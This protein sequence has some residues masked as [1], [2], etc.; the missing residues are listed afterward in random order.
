MNRTLLFAMRTC[1][2]FNSLSQSVRISIAPRKFIASLVCS[3]ESPT[4]M[5]RMQV[6]IFLHVLSFSQATCVRAGATS[7]R[8]PSCPSGFFLPHRAPSCV[9]RQG[10]DEP[11]RSAGEH[12]K[13]YAVALKS[14]L[15]GSGPAQL[16][17]LLAA[18][19][20]VPKHHTR[21][22]I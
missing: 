21:T 12:S 22:S 3:R 20:P 18:T 15:A 5:D 8:G 9:T 13:T 1:F 10:V 14:S 6:I 11:K 4:R 7:K 2:L 16:C 17:C 19:P